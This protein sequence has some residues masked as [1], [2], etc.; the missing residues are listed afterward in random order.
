MQAPRAVI[1]DLGGTLVDWSDWNEGASRC[2]N[3]S[4]D[5]LIERLPD[6][7]RPE[8]V[9]YVQAM[10]DAEQ[11][12]WRHVVEEQWSGPPSSLVGDGLR[13]VG[14]HLHEG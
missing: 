7:D 10:L 11:A 1:F 13:R 8:R 4:Y 6:G 3:V 12:H 5:Y 9:A 2:W 14:R